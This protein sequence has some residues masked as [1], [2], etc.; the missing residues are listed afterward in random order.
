MDSEE[1]NNAIFDFGFWPGGDRDGNPYVTPEI[2]LKTAKRLRFSILRN[3]YRDL[4]RLKRK[5]TFP[6]VEERVEDLERA[7][8]NALFY[9]ERNTDFSLEHV[10]SE[11]NYIY[12]S[13]KKEHKGDLIKEKD[14]LA[15]HYV[16]THLFGD[17]FDSSRDRNKT[18]DFQYLVQPLI[19][20]FNEG[21]ALTGEEGKID[22]YIPYYLAYGASAGR[23]PAYSDL[24]FE[25]EIISVNK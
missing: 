11:M 12:E 24:V 15:V 10:K 19:S 23:M 7:V 25:I 20:G 9:P 3:Y 8:F 18:L 5:L 22:L 1:L 14:K 17:K 13:I 4:R 6:G 2:T 21:L 16:G